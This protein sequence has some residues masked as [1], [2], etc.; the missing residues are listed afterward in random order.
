VSPRRRWQARSPAERRAVAEAFATLLAASLIVR[1]L[2]FRRIAA[3]ARRPVTAPAPGD[4]AAT[5]AI[6]AWA[7]DAAA[8]RARFRAVCIERGLTAQAMLRRRGIVATLHYGVAR[9]AGDLTA[10]VWVRWRG[11]D[12]VGGA[13]SAD[14]REMAVFTPREVR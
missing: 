8:R 12:V 4:P 2:P 1:F 7:V 14:F 11:R 6:V 9:R 13:E 5:V 3:I 10:H